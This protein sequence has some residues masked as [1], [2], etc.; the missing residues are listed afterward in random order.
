ML[1]TC[2]RDARR[3]GEYGLVHEV[4]EGRQHRPQRGGVILIEENPDDNAEIRGILITG[5]AT[6]IGDIDGVVKVSG[7]VMDSGKIIPGE[8]A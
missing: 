2:P 6:L 8:G 5:T 4:E 7:A 1:L 3:P